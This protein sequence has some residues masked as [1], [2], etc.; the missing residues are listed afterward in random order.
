MVNQSKGS[1]PANLHVLSLTSAWL[2]FTLIPIDCW[3]SW[4]STSS[5]WLAEQEA[6]KQTA[7]F[8]FGV[9]WP[10]SWPT[11]SLAKQYL[12]SRMCSSEIV[13]L[14]A[15]HSSKLP[16]WRVLPSS[17]PEGRE[18]HESSTTEV[19]MICIYVSLPVNLINPC[20]YFSEPIC[21]CCLEPPAR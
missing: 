5:I 12:P 11:G 15:K 20:T 13:L 2:S 8:A 16:M 18:P 1:R 6:G 9:V 21:C 14:I 7:I 19:H 10:K 17:R 4:R 3:N